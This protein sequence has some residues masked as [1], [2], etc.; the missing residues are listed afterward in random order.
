MHEMSLT[1]SMIEIVSDTAKAQGFSKVKTVWLEIGALSH[2]EPEAMRFCFEA[3]SRDTVADGAKL[4]I[5]RI[6]GAA[7]CMACSKSVEIAERYDPCPDCGGHQL[8]VT[9]GDDLRIKELEVA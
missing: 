1:E 2:A 5:I 8:Q 9:G 3:V 4:E 7:W 6:P